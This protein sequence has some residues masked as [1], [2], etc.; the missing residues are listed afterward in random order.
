M[1]IYIEDLPFCEEKGNRDG[2][3]V[4]EKVGLREEEKQVGLIVM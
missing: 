1:V 3:R 4:G 2:R